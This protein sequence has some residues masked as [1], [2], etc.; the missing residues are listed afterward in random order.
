MRKIVKPK[1]GLT[2]TAKSFIEKIDDEKEAIEKSNTPTAADL[3]EKA[4]F[5][6]SHELNKIEN[7]I[8]NRVDLD[9]KDDYPKYE[10]LVKSIATLATQ[11]R[12]I[13]KEIADLTDDQLDEKFA[14]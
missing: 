4:L 13:A 8:K 3:L 12:A 14:K 2:P 6:S 11:E 1:I 9:I 5:I 10:I 7:K